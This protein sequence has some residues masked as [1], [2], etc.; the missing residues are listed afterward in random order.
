MT[1]TLC[2]MAAMVA[3]SGC[4]NDGDPSLHPVGEGRDQGLLVEMLAEGPLHVGWNR[5]Y[6]RLTDEA[7]G[8][9][10]TMAEIAQQPVMH[11]GTHTHGCPVVDPDP[12]ADAEGLFA[13]EIVYTMASDEG[14]T[15]DQELTVEGAGTTHLVVLEDLSVAPGMHAA[16]PLDDGSAPPML[17]VTLTFVEA[18][19][20]G[21]N[22]YILTLHERTDPF[23]FHPRTD[24]EVTLVPF[25]PAHGHGS[26]GSTDPVHVAHGRYDGAV[27]LSMPGWWTLDVVLPGLDTVQFEVTF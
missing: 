7:T 19:R 23:T 12:T 21:L 13:A 17:H 5:V 11:M 20:T 14:M 24:M 4:G 18:P 3:L 2:L 1:R 25:M 6:Y 10:V 16:L 27:N 22:P 26:T 8:E 9:P 15:W